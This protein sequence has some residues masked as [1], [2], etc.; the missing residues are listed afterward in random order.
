MP[1]R[2]FWAMES[3]INRIN[4]NQD[5]RSLGVLA[6]SQSKEGYEKMSERLVLEMGTIAEVAPDLNPEPDLEGIDLL[7]QM[8]KEKVSGKESQISS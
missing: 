6:S 7:K 8:S 2:R 5:M 1:S 3:A 4:A